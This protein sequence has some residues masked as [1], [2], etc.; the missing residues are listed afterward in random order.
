M[1]DSQLNGS[2]LISNLIYLPADF[3]PDAFKDYEACLK[4]VLI[5]R[6]ET[7]FKPVILNFDALVNPHVYIAGMTGS[8]KTYLARSLMLRLCAELNCLVLMIDF[9]GEHANIGGQN[10]VILESNMIEARIREAGSGI[11]YFGFKELDEKEKVNSA[12]YILDLIVKIMRRRSLE[13]DNR[14]FVI[15]DEAWKLLGRAESLETLIREGRK[16]GVGLILASQMLDDANRKLVSN[17]ASIFIFRINDR[18]SLENL[19]KNYNL[20]EAHMRKIQN[21][22]VGSC[23]MVQVYKS[24]LRDIFVVRKVIGITFEKFIMINAGDEMNMEV[25]MDKL[26]TGIRNLCGDKADVLVS[27][28]R[29]DNFVELHSV[30]KKLITSGADRRAV[31]KLFRDFGMDDTELADAFALAITTMGGENEVIEK[32]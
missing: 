26:E 6:T 28:I 5:G 21:L 10:E 17:T 13:S 19:A 32:E 18:K 22:D 25:S 16:Y 8:G 27:E 12:S 14:I 7:N 11:L 23:L 29:R 31:L 15:L 3:E 20:N 2:G 4:G 30:I 24:E 9:T 1:R